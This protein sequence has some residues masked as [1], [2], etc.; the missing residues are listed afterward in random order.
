[1]DFSD[2]HM[3]ATHPS[4]LPVPS[5]KDSSYFSTESVLTEEGRRDMMKTVLR[6]FIQNGKWFGKVNYMFHVW[7]QM[8]KNGKI[9]PDKDSSYLFGSIAEKSER[10]ATSAPALPSVLI[11]NTIFFFLICTPLYI[12]LL[13]SPVI[14]DS[15]FNIRSFS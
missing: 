7:K 13:F 5:Y 10:S 4:F 15:L 9:M 12:S 3:M 6:K 2:A 14:S 1:M 8:H 11:T